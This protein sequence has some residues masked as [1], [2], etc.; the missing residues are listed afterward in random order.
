MTSPIGYWSCIIEY[1]RRKFKEGK[2][3]KEVFVDLNGQDMLCG[4]VSDIKLGTRQ[5]GR[6]MV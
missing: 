2:K 6:E 5:I 4:G 1:Q 3:F